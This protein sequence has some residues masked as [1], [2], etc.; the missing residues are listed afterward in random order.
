M[1]FIEWLCKKLVPIIYEL[2][3][4]LQISP[5][6]PK[7]VCYLIS[8]SHTVRWAENL[9]FLSFPW[10]SLYGM[11]RNSRMIC[12]VSRVFLRTSLLWKTL[13]Q[14][15]S[16]DRLWQQSRAMATVTQKNSAVDGTLLF[17]FCYCYC[18]WSSC[19]FLRVQRSRHLFVVLTLAMNKPYQKQPGPSNST[20]SSVLSS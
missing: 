20:H 8:N 4:A 6:Y 7:A 14:L 19:W 9:V 1:E 3:H 17:S 12:P 11:F 13:P 10:R 18:G 16:P 15:D 5:V 2:Q